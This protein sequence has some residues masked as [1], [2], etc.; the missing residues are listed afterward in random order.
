MTLYPLKEFEKAR[1]APAAVTDENGEFT[2]CSYQPGDGAPPGEYAV[3]FSWPKHLNTIDDDSGMPEVDQLQGRY[4]NP[5]TST[6]HITVR[7]GKNAL[8]PFVLP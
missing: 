6:F 8:E 1:F 4:A 5:R 2:I 7:E 3:T